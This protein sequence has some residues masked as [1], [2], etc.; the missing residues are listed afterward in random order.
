LPA[1]GLDF[2]KT[3]GLDIRRVGVRAKSSISS[4]YAAICLI[5]ILPEAWSAKAELRSLLNVPSWT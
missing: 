1:Y 3:T 2:K 4:A 5:P